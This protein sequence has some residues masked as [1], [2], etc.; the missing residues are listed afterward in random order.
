MCC[1]IIVYFLLFLTS[2]LF[3]QVNFSHSDCGVGN[4]GCTLQLWVLMVMWENGESSGHSNR[5]SRH[6]RPDKQPVLFHWAHTHVH[7]VVLVI[8]QY[9]LVVNLI[10]CSQIFFQYRT[11]LPS[12]VWLLHFAWVEDHEKCIVVTH[13][14]VSVCLSVCV[15]PRPHAHTIART[16][17]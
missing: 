7:I 15:S 14:C 12:V 6:R 11:A 3:V 5:S 10:C 13:V 4:S 17:M 16:R 8:G 1:L 2:F 9:I